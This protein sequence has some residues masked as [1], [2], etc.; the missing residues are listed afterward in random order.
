MPYLGIYEEVA[1]Y[2]CDLLNC[3]YALVA[4]PEKDSIR[5]EAIAGVQPESTDTLA[6]DLIARLTE[7]G[8][9]VIDEFRM[10]VVPV[11]SGSEISAILAG[12]RNAPASFTTSDL[13][14]LLDYSNVAASLLP[15]LI[16][17]NTQTRTSFTPDELLHFSRLIT[18]GQMSACFAHEVTNPL[19][20]I[21]GHLQF[22]EESLPADHPL[23]IHFD[24]IDRASRRIEEMS[25]KM[26]DFSRKR[27]RRT[28]PSDLAEILSDALKFVQPFMRAQL[29]DIQA[30]IEPD[31]PLVRI[32]RW[33][34]AQA[35]VNLLRNAGD[36]MADTNRRVLSVNA[37]REGTQ[38]RIVVSDTG[39][40]ITPANMRRLFEP[41]FTTKGERGTGLG[42][43]I[44]RQV[45]EDHRG[46][47]NVHTD[48]HG[49]SFV[50]SLP[51]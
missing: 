4:V 21:R 5:I 26:L 27:V 33:Q 32:D 23:W 49:T 9:V 6:A 51:L 29:V 15:G 43:Y 25:K 45:I 22:V 17:V 42:L 35:I 28:E 19:T 12:Y 24:V 13:A 44:T 11:K 50:I 46:T 7:W 3:D 20:L 16:P 31:M 14:K 47:I 36:A 2:V 48:H 39:P 40:G 18:I 30:Q 1:T 38:L 37:G 41:F 34:M 10:I 8:P